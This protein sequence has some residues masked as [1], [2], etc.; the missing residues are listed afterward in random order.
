MTA[1]D[2]MEL[3]NVPSKLWLNY[4]EK[5]CNA[6]NREQHHHPHQPSLIEEAI[7]SKPSNLSIER[8]CHLLKMKI[9]D[10]ADKIRKNFSTP[11]RRRSSVE[12]TSSKSRVTQEQAEFHR[13]PKLIRPVERVQVN[14][15]SLSELE[16]Q[17]KARKKVFSPPRRRS[18]PENLIILEAPGTP[19]RIGTP[20][21][22]QLYKMKTFGETENEIERKYETPGKQSVRRRRSS[23]KTSPKS[24]ETQMQ[25][26]IHRSPQP[27]RPDRVHDN[28]QQQI[29]MR[30]RLMD[31]TPRRRRSSPE[32]VILFE[33]PKKVLNSPKRAGNETG[34][35]F[36]TRNAPEHEFGRKYKI[37]P[38]EKKRQI[39]YKTV[40]TTY[41]IKIN[42]KINF[43][44]YSS[45][46]RRKNQV[47]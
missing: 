22:R 35:K 28:Q 42:F 23:V 13:S 4:L 29:K 30:L 12:L 19:K 26:E 25:A 21:T 40:S 37:S 2:S 20:V 17:L 5:V 39:Y 15:F 34:N 44:W 18:S 8:G 6:L 1:E 14:Q 47:D 43:S 36:K 3:V 46:Q 31:S 27:S 10:S 32:N 41:L 9:R 45:D 24:H 16:Q 33:S 38:R 7:A 11:R